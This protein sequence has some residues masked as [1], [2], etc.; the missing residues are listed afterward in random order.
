MPN[1]LIDSFGRVHTYLRISVTDRCNL[2]CRYCMP[3]DGLQWKQKDELLSFEEIEKL[4]KI[5]AAM[6]INKVRLTGGEPL[7]RQEL[8]KLVAKLKAIPGIE[9]LAMTTN[10]T[11][12]ARQ[13]DD[14]KSAGM[15]ALN[16]SLD[17][18]KRQRFNEITRLDCFDQVMQGIDSALQTGFDSL[19][20]NMVVMSGIN[21]DEVLDFAQFAQDH[22]VNVRFI[23]FMPFKDNH[24]QLDKVVTFAQI[25]ERLEK[26]FVLT[27]QLTEA[28][29]VA[30]DFKLNQAGSVSFITSM[31]ESFCGTCNRL[32]LTSDGSMKSCLFF[33]AEINLRD[34][35]RQN[36]S[37]ET[38]KGMILSCLEAKPEAH[39]PAHE[40]A[41][42]E[43]RTMIEI[44]G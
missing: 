18:F 6:G 15:N 7:M 31:S 34:A 33:P 37:E 25:K 1:Q 2:R 26:H 30:K 9:T 3:L 13:A 10:A 8:V 17:S 44:G 28:S 21:D 43:N 32:R 22:D 12:L 5:L 41:S 19:K 39:P 24:W 20:I 27:P 36:S 35:L 4:T 14:L 40:I 42:S 16:I 23:E 29:A 38:L 11:M